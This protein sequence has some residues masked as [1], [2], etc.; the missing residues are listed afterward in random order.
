MYYWPQADALSINIET[1][2][3]RNNQ[4]PSIYR[5]LSDYGGVSAPSPWRHIGEMHHKAECVVW[6]TTPNTPIA[7]VRS[8]I[9]RRVFDLYDSILCEPRRV[10]LWSL[11]QS[12]IFSLT[13]DL[14][15]PS[16]A[17][18]SQDRELYSSTSPARD[19]DYDDTTMTLAF[20]AG[21]NTETP[22][23][24]LSAFGWDL[25]GQ[26]TD[27]ELTPSH[28]GMVSHTIQLVHNGQRPHLAARYSMSQD[29]STQKNRLIYELGPGANNAPGV[30]ANAPDITRTNEGLYRQAFAKG[31]AAEQTQ[32]SSIEYAGFRSDRA[33]V[34][35]SSIRLGEKDLYF[36]A[37][38]DY[39]TKKNT[40]QRLVT[41]WVSIAD[42]EDAALSVVTTG[43]TER[44][45]VDIERRSDGTRLP[46]NVLATNLGRAPRRQA[47]K[48][49]ADP[50]ERYHFV[51][52]SRD[53]RAAP[54]VDIELVDNVAALLRS[55]ENAITVLDL[56]AMRAVTATN[57]LRIFPQP[58]TDKLTV[59]MPADSG[60]A[61]ARRMQLSTLL[62]EVIMEFDVGTAPVVD[63]D[64]S[65]IPT[66]TYV[67]TLVESNTT[68]RTIVR[69]AR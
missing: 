38:E 47:W 13:H 69:I 55:T 61:R 23:M 65:A 59:V 40:D 7:G 21:A 42:M 67:L 11:P 49:G 57:V 24:W 1:A 19:W 18:G 56:R 39:T 53:R 32:R 4:Y 8:S 52:E 63:I 37:E 68:M 30:Y 5:H 36:H 51:I 43:E 15:A 46:L 34:F 33:E 6:Q 9:E 25:Y 64:V 35:V 26:D 60:A 29:R 16:I 3:D 27:W 14:T 54:T 48:L 45:D 41:P 66:G 28:I 44:Y 50:T 20:S 58:A 12:R 62:G 17:Q 22:A 31:D 2:G 10:D